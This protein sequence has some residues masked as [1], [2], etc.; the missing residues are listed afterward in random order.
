MVKAGYRRVT[1]G[2]LAGGLTALLLLFL[3]LNAFNLTFLFPRS[4][5]QLFLFT[6]LSVVV[7]LLLLVLLLLLFRNI[8]KL[9]ADERSRVLGS[10]IRTRMLLGALLLSFAPAFF[11]FLFSYLLMNRT[12]DRWFTQPVSQ[13]RDDSTHVALQLTQ[14]AVANA[15]AEAASLAA[16]PSI[17]KS[18]A[19]RDYVAINA[20]I[21]EHRI[22][23][24]GGFVFVYQGSAL[25]AS[26]HAPDDAK[27]GPLK[28]WNAEAGSEADV[29]EEAQRVLGP[30]SALALETSRKSDEP[31]LGVG[32]DDYVL[33]AAPVA[34]NFTIVCGFPMPDGF[35]QTV[36]SIRV[37]ARDFWTLRRARNKIR[38]LYL[39]VIFLLTALVF[40]TSSW[41]ALFLS[42]G[43]TR[44]V[45][46]LAD[47]MDAIAKGQYSHRIPAGTV[48]ELGELVRSFNAM[49][50][51]LERTR[52]LAD[53]STAQ[54]SDANRA[55]QERRRELET[56]LQTIPTGVIILNDELRMQQSNQAATEL[57]APD[58]LPEDSVTEDEG[59]PP[60]EMLFPS[61]QRDD[62]WRMI[63]RC[64]RIGVAAGDFEFRSRGQAVHL[65]VTVALLEVEQR[66]RGYIMVLEDVTES[67]RAQRQ[68]AWKEAAQRVAHEIK[69]PLTP[70]ALS[71]GRIQRHLERGTPESPAVI[72]RCSEVILNSVETMR[73]LV[74][75]FAALAQFPV[76]QIRPVDLNAIVRGAIDSFAGRLDR[77]VVVQRLAAEGV[78]VAADA[79]GL[80]ARAW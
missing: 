60:L 2:W 50:A 76:P 30:L 44:P 21:A 42:K 52:E 8:L 38:G 35:R 27:A 39:L 54:L 34:N 69:N 59:H 9:Y 51:D 62:L 48:K 80:D 70:I 56:I 33:A 13:L 66:R 29:P 75:E 53:S 12:I 18:L 65:T 73:T 19:K 78:M 63:R 36:S 45:E 10:R 22:T 7:F 68:V 55:L 43:I 74:D 77:I 14:Y 11:L 4:T 6:G 49:A 71:A 25:R 40:F 79:A 3:S 61:D 41:L 28:T 26:F 37:G 15:R 17:Q 47:A 20:A 64:Q 32:A 5:G 46:A 57:L 72:R 31:I 1:V 67:L 58:F 23:L 16:S 24:E